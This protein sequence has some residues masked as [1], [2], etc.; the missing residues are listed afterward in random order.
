MTPNRND[1]SRDAARNA[2]ATPSPTQPA[3]RAVRAHVAHAP[4]PRDGWLVPG[5][6]GRA[7]EQRGAP[8]G[9][10]TKETARI[11]W[12]KRR[13]RHTESLPNHDRHQ[14]RPRPCE[15]LSPPA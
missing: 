6:R 2:L 7:T 10:R 3:G 13:E 5:F 4:C 1:R 12:R 8:G 11:G 14:L 9:D 15:Q